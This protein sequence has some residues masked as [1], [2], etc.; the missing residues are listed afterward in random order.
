MQPLLINLPTPVELGQRPAYVLLDQQRG[1]RQAL[2]EG[3]DDLRIWWAISQSNG[4]VALPALKADTPDGGALG[5]FEKLR[6]GPGKK[7]EQRGAVEIVAWL[8]IHYPGGF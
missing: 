8:E 3:G 6:L 2:I 1:F 4:N 5:A 7:L